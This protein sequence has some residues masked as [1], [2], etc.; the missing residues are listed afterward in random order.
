[1]AE[2][3]RLPSVPSPGRVRAARVIAVLADLAQIVLLPVFAV[4]GASPWDDTLDLAVAAAMTWLVGWHWAFLPTFLSELVPFWDLV[5]T[6]TAAVFFA[7]RGMGRRAPEHIVKGA[8]D[9]E[10]VSRAAD[11]SPAGNTSE[12]RSR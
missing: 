11:P 12:S 3:P 1:M 4:G 8:I 5:P 9:T 6:W 10:V 7:T 2:P